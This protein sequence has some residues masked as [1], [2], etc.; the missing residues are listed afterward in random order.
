MT[1]RGSVIRRAA[2][3]LAIAAFAGTGWTSARLWFAW[4][5]VARVAFE[6]GDARSALE[7]PNNTDRTPTTIPYVEEAIDPL[8]STE[9][10]AGGEVAVSPDEYAAASRAGADETMDVY[11][12]LGSDERESLGS[13]RRADTIMVLMIPTDGSTPVLVSIPR[14]LYLRN[15]CSGRMTRINANLN[16]CGSYATGPEQVAIAVED[17]AGVKIDHFVVFTFTGFRRIV[18]RVGGVEICTDSAVRD[19]GVDPIPLNLP[20]GCS[21]V[22]GDQAL[23]WVRSRHTKGFIDGRWVD[24][25]SN[26]LV[27]NQRQQDILLQAMGKVTEMHDI[28]ELA[29]LAAELASEFAIDDGITLASAVATAWELRRL[30]IAGIAR[31]VLPVAD[32][33]DPDG[34]W[35]LV[36]RATFESIVVAANPLLAPYFSPAD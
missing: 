18:D 16:G 34:R 5:D 20:A 32:Y 1:A 35:V 4:N 17:F 24:L 33:V 7:D 3:V 26:D 23:A 21:R 10:V 11:L 2:I 27:R 31:P 25:G 8:E 22:S 12:V 28:S 30:D 6:P 13:S 9:P 14:D 15:P 29:A 19:L 36:P